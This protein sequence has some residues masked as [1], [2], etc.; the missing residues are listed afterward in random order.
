MFPLQLGLC[1]GLDGAKE[2]KEEGY[3]KGIKAKIG[4]FKSVATIEGKGV[5]C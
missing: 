1:D 2:L 5:L 4:L 3:R